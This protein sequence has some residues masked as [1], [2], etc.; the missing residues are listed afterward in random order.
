MA[1]MALDLMVPPLTLL[2]GLVMLAAAM[3]VGMLWLD[4]HLPSWMAVSC[5][6]VLVAALLWAWL[7]VGRDLLSASDLLRAPVH[8]LMK[9]PIYLKFLT[10][11]QKDWV[12]TERHDD[13]S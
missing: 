8:A 6:T 2:L 13:K 4:L 1:A 12:R 9:F 10:N 5:L 3:S 7:Q 11:R